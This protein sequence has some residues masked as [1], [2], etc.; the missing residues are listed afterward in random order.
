MDYKIDAIG[1]MCPLPIMRA[2]IKLLELKPYDRVILKT[3]H[4]CSSAS[5]INHFQT[6]YDYPCQVQQIDEGIW[7]IIIEKR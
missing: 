7:E 2:E 6:K 4:S 3:D 5:V 1:E